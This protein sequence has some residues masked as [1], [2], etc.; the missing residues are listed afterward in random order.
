MSERTIA[1]VGLVGGVPYGAA[2][3]DAIARADVVVG[4]QRH[5][6]QVEIAAASS[7]IDLSGPLDKVLDQ[8]AHEDERGRSLCVLSSGD[9][10]F[11]GIVRLL[12]ER[13]GPERLAVHPAP[14]SVSLAFAAVG[15]T[16]DD[17]IIA[18]AH[19]RPIEQAVAAVTHAPKA[20]ILT[21]P[22][23]PPEAVG[24]A[25]L[26]VGAPPRQ[27]VVVTRI[28]EEGESITRTDLDGLTAGTFD[29]MSV[30]VLLMP[31]LQHEEPIRWGL[32]E[33]EFAHRDGMITKAEVRAVALGKLALP[34]DGV[35]WDIGA[36]SGSV[37]IEC[38]RLA[39]RLRVIAI[40]RDTEQV[41][42]IRENATAHR[43][44]VRIVEGTAPSALTDLPDPD[45]VFIGGGGL[46]ALDAA[47][48]RLRPGGI[49]VANYALMDRATAAHQRLGN[50]VQV[51]VS[52]GA[53]I[54]GL[55]VR[56]DAENPV[57]I[58]WG[59]S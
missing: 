48:E 5:R 25:L 52:R 24:K 31:V 51:C 43:T 58:C 21:S 26:A 37:A 22:T 29:P 38:A 14:S 46:D 2:A 54:A 3:L 7:C 59:P 13:F 20:A 10:G 32:P 36:G 11:F 9:P 19:G 53:P 44:T 56:L 15:H 1:V 17:A 16:W 30:L 47:L 45:R 4:S 23:N 50:I 35:L 18:S 49:I 57:F 28:G 12:G 33:T 39:P 41:I 55:G 8:L 40:E 34:T 42:R 6:D 27:V